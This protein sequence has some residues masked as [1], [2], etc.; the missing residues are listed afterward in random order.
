MNLSN[1]SSNRMSFSFADF[2]TSDDEIDEEE[3][4]QELFRLAQEAKEKVKGWPNSV[5]PDFLWDPMINE[6]DDFIN[7]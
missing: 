5:F 1:D 3:H 4:E 6:F 7:K 2:D